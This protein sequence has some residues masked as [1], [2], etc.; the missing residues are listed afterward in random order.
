MYIA[1]AIAVGIAVIYPIVRLTLSWLFP[2][3]ARVILSLRAE[4]PRS[5]DVARERGAA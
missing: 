1:V 4:H 2:K 3:D 5:H